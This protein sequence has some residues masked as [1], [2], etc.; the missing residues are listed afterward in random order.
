MTSLM[1]SLRLKRPSV[2]PPHSTAS[3]S[4]KLDVGRDAEIK[5][6]EEERRQR[7]AETKKEEEKRKGKSMF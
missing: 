4:I 1:R 2:M 6:E 5:K 7:E 3:G